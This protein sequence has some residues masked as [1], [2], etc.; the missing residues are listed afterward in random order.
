MLRAEHHYHS[1]DNLGCRNYLYAMNII[2][3]TLEIDASQQAPSSI[4][5]QL[6]F[7]Q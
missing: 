4:P 7:F 5:L 6:P 3:R 2:R 1:L